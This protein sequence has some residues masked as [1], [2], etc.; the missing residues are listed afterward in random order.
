MRLLLAVTV[1][2]GLDLVSFSLIVPL[3][4]IGAESNGLMARAYLELGIFGV[5]FLKV[6]CTVLILTLLVRVR[7]S[8]LRKV[9]AGLGVAIGLVGFVGNL[10][11]LAR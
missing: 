9:A 11:A 6:A 7:R 4:G 8:D 10:A 1:A 3:V 5:A 2:M